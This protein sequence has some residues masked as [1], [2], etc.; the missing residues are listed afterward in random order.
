MLFHA[1]K[2][3]WLARLNGVIIIEDDDVMVSTHH[4]TA[5]HTERV[6]HQT[7]VTSIAI[8]IIIAIVTSVTVLDR[9]YY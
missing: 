6:N 7:Q 8:V 4:C 1:P 5:L 3:G 9:G 2:N